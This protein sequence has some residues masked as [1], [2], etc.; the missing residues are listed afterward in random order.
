MTLKEAIDRTMNRM[1]LNQ[2]MLAE[3][4]DTN[5]STV[6]KMRSGAEWEQHWQ[7]FLKLADLCQMAAIDLT[8]GRHIKPNVRDI[9]KATLER[10]ARNVLERETA[11][12]SITGYDTFAAAGGDPRVADPAAP[13]GAKKRTK[14]RA[15]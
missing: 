12:K 3:R 1:A 13:R 10:A 6:S 2:T 9:A 4:L 14:R 15:D 11:S 7:I 5:Q 8:Q